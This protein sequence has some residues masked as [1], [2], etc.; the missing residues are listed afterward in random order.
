MLEAMPTRL[1]LALLALLC[2]GT[3]PTATVSSLTVAQTRQWCT[4]RTTKFEALYSAAERKSLRCNIEGLV[5]PSLLAF[6]TGQALPAPERVRACEDQLARC[7]ETP[8][9]CETAAVDSNCDATV[10]DVEACF[11]AQ[12]VALSALMKGPRCDLADPD[13]GP[14]LLLPACP[15]VDTRCPGRG[16]L[17]P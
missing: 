8:P 13:A 1:P 10:E 11:E 7:T 12:L 15:R 17:F 3:P 4:E 5:L 9:R 2:C 16:I 14:G 6:N